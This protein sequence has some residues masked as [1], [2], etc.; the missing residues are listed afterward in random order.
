VLLLVTNYN[1]NSFSFSRFRPIK[2]KVLFFVSLK[3]NIDIS[4]EVCFFVIKLPNLHPSRL[5]DL[6][7]LSV[8]EGKTTAL[9]LHTMPLIFH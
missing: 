4:F 2:L 9:S 1:L 5:S 8:V 6:I 7:I 3:T